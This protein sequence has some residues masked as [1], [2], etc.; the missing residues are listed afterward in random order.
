MAEDIAKSNGGTDQPEIECKV[1]DEQAK[2]VV[3]FK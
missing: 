3:F 2:V 1:P